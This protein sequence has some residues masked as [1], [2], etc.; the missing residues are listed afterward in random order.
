MNLIPYNPVAG[1]PFERPGPADVERF[2]GILRERR[3]QRDG[4]EEQGTVDRRRVR[5]APR[6]GAEADRSG[7]GLPDLSGGA[8][9]GDR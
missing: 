5:P 9:R 2:V 1:L 4:A 6:G 7:P 3:V 8:E